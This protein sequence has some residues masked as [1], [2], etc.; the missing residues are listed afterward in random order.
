MVPNRTTD[1]L[2]LTEIYVWH[3]VKGR[4]AGMPKAAEHSSG[5]NIA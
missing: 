4:V 5:E 3:I 1:K 2:N